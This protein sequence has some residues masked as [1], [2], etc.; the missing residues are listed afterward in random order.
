MRRRVRLMYVL[1]SLHT[2]QQVVWLREANALWRQ[3][4]ADRGEAQNAKLE[5]LMQTEEPKID[6][7]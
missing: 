7:M 6:E 1:S 3:V 2:V 4:K 5:D